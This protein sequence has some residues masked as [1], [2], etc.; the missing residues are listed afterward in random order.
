M[1]SLETDLL[2]VAQIIAP[3]FP[4]NPLPDIE[5]RNLRGVAYGYCFYPST[6]HPHGLITV[7]LPV[8]EAAWKRRGQQ[9]EQVIAHE[10]VHHHQHYQANHQPSRFFTDYT[11]WA[12]QPTEWEAEEISN[13]LLG[14]TDSQERWKITKL[15]VRYRYGPKRPATRRF[16]VF[17]SN[18]LTSHNT[19]ATVKVRHEV[20]DAYRAPM[21]LS[22]RDQAI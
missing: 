10:L 6:E 4:D 12:S 7:D 20:I 15:W 11:R 1:T 16:R 17:V 13:K 14:S 9:L 8:I 5:A 21:G 22:P 18:P 3:L 2:I 19:C